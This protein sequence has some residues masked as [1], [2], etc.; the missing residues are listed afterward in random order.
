M[1]EVVTVPRVREFMRRPGRAGT[2]PTSVF[3]TGGVSATLEGW[4]DSTVDID[5]RFEPDD[6]GCYESSSR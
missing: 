6:E 1:R 4:R 3:F 2:R 5:L